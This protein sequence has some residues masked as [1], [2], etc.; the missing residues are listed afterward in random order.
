LRLPLR[1]SLRL[2]LML[3]LWRR[4]RLL[5]QRRLALGAGKASR[6]GQKADQRTHL[7]LHRDKFGAWA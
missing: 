2:L 1:L 6:N 7:V 3:L 5:P 4:W